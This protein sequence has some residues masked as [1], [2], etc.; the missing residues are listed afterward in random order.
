MLL[1]CFFSV[2][3][4][5]YRSYGFL[6]ALF[7]L[8]GIC[9]NLNILCLYAYSDLLSPLEKALFC[10]SPLLLLLTILVAV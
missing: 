10:H 1:Y 6:L 4:L 3:G 5:S 7:R 2:F 9:L 8:F